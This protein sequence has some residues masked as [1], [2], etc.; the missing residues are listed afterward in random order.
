MKPLE[1]MNLFTQIALFLMQFV[2]SRSIRV[3]N[4]TFNL[5][6]RNSSLSVESRMDQRII[7]SPMACAQLCLTN[8][9]CEAF[10]LD[11]SLIS[12][13]SCE[14]FSFSINSTLEEVPGWNLYTIY[15]PKMQSFTYEVF[16]QTLVTQLADGNWKLSC[17][18]NIL[19]GL[20]D[21]TAA[22]VDFDLL[23]CVNTKDM[24]LQQGGKQFE[25]EV[26]ETNQCPRN[27]VISAFIS[28]SN[29]MANVVKLEC[30]LVGPGWLVNSFD[31]FTIMRTKN[32]AKGPQTAY[33]KW[34]FECLQRDDKDTS[35]GRREDTTRTGPQVSFLGLE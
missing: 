14:T 30:S 8:P 22:K 19:V 1:I 16:D 11:P 20:W 33:D 31:C 5:V 26:S 15:E 35:T 17:G 29:N 9:Q 21:D 28:T 27:S 2:I 3:Q 7:K 6:L 4:A 23:K 25:V 24:A 10:S 32:E 18:Q 34:K 12:S 13:T